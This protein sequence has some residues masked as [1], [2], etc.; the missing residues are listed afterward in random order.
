MRYYKK[1]KI[2]KMRRLKLITNLALVLFLLIPSFIDI[3]LPNNFENSI[4]EENQEEIIA[5]ETEI[6]NDDQIFGSNSPFSPL[7]SYSFDNSTHRYLF[8]AQDELPT[9]SSF[10]LNNFTD[11]GGTLIFSPWEWQNGQNFWGFC[12]IIENS[13]ISDHSP[14]IIMSALAST[15]CVNI[16]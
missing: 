10:I 4:S 8:I 11:F 3:F 6:F 1:Q 14:Q 5:V 13:Q 16:L 9:S 15:N 12:G 7:S 2:E